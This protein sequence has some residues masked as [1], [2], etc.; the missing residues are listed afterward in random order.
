M[1]VKQIIAT[2]VMTV[3]ATSDW[4]ILIAKTLCSVSWTLRRVLSTLVNNSP[5][6]FAICEWQTRR[7]PRVRRRV[8][9]EGGISGNP[10]SRATYNAI[11]ID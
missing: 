6:L 3:N 8:H 11:A 4:F 2:Q 10:V 9:Y 1:Y 5:Y 7:F